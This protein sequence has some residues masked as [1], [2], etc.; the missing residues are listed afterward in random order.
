MLLHLTFLKTAAGLGAAVLQVMGRSP[1]FQE[2]TLF[3]GCS[4]QDSARLTK[5]HCHCL[6]RRSGDRQT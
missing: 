3:T 2:Q 1:T 6:V 4:S 5:L